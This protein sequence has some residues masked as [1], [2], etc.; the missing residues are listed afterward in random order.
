MM[1]KI[2]QFLLTDIAFIVLLGLASAA[3]IGA[4]QMFLVDGVGATNE[5]FVTELLTTGKTTGDYSG[6][7]SFAAGFLLARLLEAPLVGILDIGGALMTGIGIGIP[8]LALDLGYGFVMQSFLGA[9]GFGFVVGALIGC[10]LILLKKF[11]P[12][13]F[14]IAA[15][16]VMMGAGNKT[17][18]ALGPLVVVYAVSYSLPAGIGAIIG[19]SLFYKLDKP[20]VGGAIIGSMVVCSIF[21]LLGLPIHPLPKQ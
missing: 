17:G 10:F 4:T 18:E 8:A 12:Q 1:K 11:M 2:E 9:L 20:I 3:V 13:N 15:T 21:L 5:I 6:A 19:A 16:A 14:P 7:S